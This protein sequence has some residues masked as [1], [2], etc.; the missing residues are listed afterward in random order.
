[1]KNIKTDEAITLKYVNWKM[2]CRSNTLILRKA[3][4]LKCPSVLMQVVLLFS[5]PLSFH[6]ARGLQA[7]SALHRQPPN[8]VK[9]PTL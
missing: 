4:N 2:L 3:E 9:K 7:T 5:K 6:A 8:K 1:M